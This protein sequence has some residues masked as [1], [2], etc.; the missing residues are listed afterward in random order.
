MR[1]A[2]YLCIVIVT[3]LLTL[4]YG[5]SLIVPFVTAFLLWFLTFEVRKSLNRLPFFD[6]YL[7]N[8]LKNVVVFALMVFIFSSLIE[9]LRANISSLAASFRSY[10]A[11][12]EQ[13]F[14]TIEQTLRNCLDLTAVNFPF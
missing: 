12:L 10:E 4:I 9:I 11:N 5:K 6:K 14:Q 3:V 7:P 2:A 13:V 8:W 1:Q